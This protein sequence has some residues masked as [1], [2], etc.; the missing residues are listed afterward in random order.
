MIVKLKWLT[1]Q[2]YF[3]HKQGGRLISAGAKLMFA[4]LLSF[5]KMNTLENN[6]VTLDT[7]VDIRSIQEL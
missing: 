7:I 1:R 4:I 3:I 5:A 2:I 6:Y